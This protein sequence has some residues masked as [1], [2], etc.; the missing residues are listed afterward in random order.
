MTIADLTPLQR[1]VY[2]VLTA[3]PRLTTGLRI[4]QRHIE[5]VQKD[6]LAEACRCFTADDVENALAWYRLHNNHVEC[7]RSYADTYTAGTE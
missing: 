5:Q 4:T 3:R 7:R 1:L 2:D 6:A